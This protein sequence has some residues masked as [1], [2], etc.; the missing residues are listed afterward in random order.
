MEWEERRV[1]EDFADRDSAVRPQPVP[2]GKNGGFMR[3]KISEF[4]V[5]VAVIQAEAVDLFDESVGILSLGK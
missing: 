5:N 3:Q 2:E 4:E 1:C